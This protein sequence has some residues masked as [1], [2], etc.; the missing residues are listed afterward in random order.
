ML[1]LA[2][3]TLLMSSA[4]HAQSVAVDEDAPRIS[5][6]QRLQ[7]YQL[8]QELKAKL[9]AVTRND[10]RYAHYLADFEQLKKQTGTLSFRETAAAFRNKYADLQKDLLRKSGIDRR[11]YNLRL[12]RILPHVQLNTAG[13]IVNP[14]QSRAAISR[15]DEST[16][17]I[18]ATYS[19]PDDTIET[20]SFLK[21]WSFQDCSQAVVRFKEIDEFT[22]FGNTT[23]S[24]DDCDDVK[25]ARGATLEVPSGVKSVRV[26]LTLD[27]Y[28]LSTDVVTPLLFSYGNAYAAVGIRVRGWIV[29][30]TNQTNY[31]R[32]KYLDTVWSVAGGD[33]ANASESGDVILRC[34]FRPLVPGEYRIFAYG[35]VWA[36]TDGLAISSGSV[37]VEG[38]RKIKVTFRR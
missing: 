33:F 3:I 25:G 13:E 9:D 7:L 28:A 27:K 32:H 34:S 15:Q 18:P 24:E 14:K 19:P 26:E 16:M 22:I 12:K 20:H 37:V 23:A 36:T 21:T 31:F 17:F 1:G 10:P 11:A 8:N 38:L 29:G 35:R 5:A 30:S 6:A 4:A 2:V